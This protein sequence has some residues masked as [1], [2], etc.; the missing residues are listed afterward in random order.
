LN[1]KGIVVGLSITE[2]T[3]NIYVLA[4]PVKGLKKRKIVSSHTNTGIHMDFL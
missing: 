2:V 3:W 4:P 1:V